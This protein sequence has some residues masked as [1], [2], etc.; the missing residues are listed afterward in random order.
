V[1]DRGLHGEAVEDLRDDGE[2]P[3]RR[4]GRARQRQP[5]RQNVRWIEA[6]VG[7][8]QREET[9]AEQ[10]RADEQDAGDGDL[11]GHDRQPRASSTR[12]P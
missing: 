8:Q 10:R 12:T 5:G 2:A 7:M 11:P 9:P 1:Q 6:A 4:V 3:L